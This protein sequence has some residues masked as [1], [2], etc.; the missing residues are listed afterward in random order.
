MLFY[1]LFL[2]ARLAQAGRDTVCMC[3]CIVSGQFA[4]CMLKIPACT[5]IKAYT[6]GL[7]HLISKQP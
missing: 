1:N 2:V 4:T 5:R 3:H 7:F 6:S